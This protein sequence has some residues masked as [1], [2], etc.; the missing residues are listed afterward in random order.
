M[1]IVENRACRGEFGVEALEVL[2]M[3]RDAIRLAL[4]V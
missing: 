3:M 2:K 1:I 4:S